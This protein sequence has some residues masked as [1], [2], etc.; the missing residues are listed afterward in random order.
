MIVAAHLITMLRRDYLKIGAVSVTG[1]L[2]LAGCT[3][4][5]GGGDGENGDDMGGGENGNDT[6]GGEDN[7]TGMGEDDNETEGG[8][9][10]GDEDG[11]Y[12]IVPSS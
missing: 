3:D 2:G 6:G 10:S 5:L 7:E 12:N 1:F 8:E 4:P 9:D 11:T